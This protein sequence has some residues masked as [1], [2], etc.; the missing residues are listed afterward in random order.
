MPSLVA[1]YAGTFNVIPPPFLNL[2]FSIHE[3]VYRLRHKRAWDQRLATRSTW[4]GRL[5]PMFT[6]WEVMNRASEVKP[7]LTSHFGLVVT[8]VLNSHAQY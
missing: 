2:R 3:V 8:T 7:P 1:A 6:L 5:F 4:S